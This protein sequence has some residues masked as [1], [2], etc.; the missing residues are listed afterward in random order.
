MKP[1]K[2]AV[3]KKMIALFLIVM[4]PSV[5][6]AEGIPSREVVIA[7]REGLTTFL[8]EIK[9][10]NLDRFGFYSQADISGAQLGPAFQI[11]TIPPDKILS[12]DPSI[13]DLSSMIVPTN[14]WQFLIISQGN[15]KSLLTVDFFKD[16]WTAVSIGASGLA[17]QLSKIT[18]A[19]PASA[20]YR[21]RL[22]RVYQAKSD[23]LEMSL[24]ERVI[25]IVPLLSARMALGSEKEDFDPLDLQD[26][27]NI[28]IN[29][30]PVVEKSLQEG[31]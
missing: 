31:K 28:V 14:Q 2:T 10:Q 1:V 7:A 23:F 13:S 21:C 5:V 9:A 17:M 25:G 18:E 4:L 8:Y 27:R 24:G 12:Y 26:S 22:I 3:L 11:F 30:K 29:L 6:A 20:G 15:P 19:W 16:E